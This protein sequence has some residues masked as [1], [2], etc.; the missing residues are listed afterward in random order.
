MSELKQSKQNVVSKVNIESNHQIYINSLQMKIRKSPFSV[1]GVVVCCVGGDPDPALQLQLQVH[2]AQLLPPP[3][4]P[5]TGGPL[6][7]GGGGGPPPPPSFLPS[8]TVKRHIAT[9]AIRTSK[10]SF[11]ISNNK[12][13]YNSSF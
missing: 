2:G 6:P 4:P 1:P 13:K 5:L 11:A 10:A 9:A 3:P 7:C 12:T 8:V